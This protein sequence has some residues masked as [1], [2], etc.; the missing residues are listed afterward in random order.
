M[1]NVFETLMALLPESPKKR[2]IRAKYNNLMAARQ[3]GNGLADHFELKPKG[4][5]KIEAID[6]NGRVTGTLADQSNLVV[7]GAEEIMMK[8]LAGDPAHVLYQNRFLKQDESSVYFI[9]TDHLIDV[10]NGENVLAVLPND[11]WS[12]V[13]E[14]EFTT[15]F[16]FSPITVYLVEV[17]S[18][19]PGQKA[20]KI[21]K[22]PTAET[23]SLT[24]ELYSGY[25]PLFI[26]IGDGKNYHVPFNSGLLTLSP[27][28]GGDSERKTTTLNDKITFKQKITNFQVDYK[29][30][31][32]G[33]QFTI[34][35][36][37]KAV[38]T[39]DTYD[40]DL[41]D[42]AYGDGSVVIDSLDPLNESDV[43][44]KFSGKNDA[45]ETPELTIHALYFDA[46]QKN[47]NKLIHELEDFTTVFDTPAYYNTSAGAPYYVQLDHFPVVPS[48]VKVQYN[49]TTFE[50]VEDQED[51]AENKYFVDN[52][53]G[54]IYFT[55]ALT[56][57]LITYE[58]TGQQYATFN[59]KDL[60]AGTIKQTVDSETPIGAIDGQNKS[61]SLANKDIIPES[62]II[63]FSDAELKRGEDYTINNEDGTIAFNTAP[64]K[65]GTITASYQ[66]GISAKKLSF[67]DK[68]ID[69]SIMINDADRGQSYSKVD[70]SSDFKA[71]TFILN[72]DDED[73]KSIL[74]L[75]LTD[76]DPEKAGLEIFFKTDDLPGVPTNYKRQLIV[77]PKRGKDAPW[78]ALDK[79]EIEFVTEFPENLPAMNM[80][81]RE[82]GLFD[83]PRS[84][85]QVRGY[86]NYP[87]KAFSLV[88]V[89]DS[90]K[91]ISTGIRITW[92]ITLLNEDGQPFHGGY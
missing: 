30:S 16:S 18:T 5:I 51:L 77:K 90:I 61:F 67:E 64:A 86:N 58:I 75:P 55:S 50:P 15:E 6:N 24:A 36:N 53:Y 46:F 80:T 33:G 3:K 63:K 70:A 43:E 11:I 12:V 83:G 49:S 48:S 19:R 44:I 34:S 41:A 54:K 1:S 65:G 60:E 21:V 27:G 72:P 57:L 40:K 31:K 14:N 52:K 25:S 4:H 17:E 26:G 8:A 88:R 91:E 89:G 73:H 82:M 32:L 42:G 81:I 39:V 22:D 62:E 47:D 85:D 37:G 38:K 68:L 84:E 76:V 92:T 13:D 45:V 79:G 56:N 23:A 2:M 66:F 71:G 78:F 87:V 35:V 20:F 7:N 29:T 59:L 28:F 74:L 9:Q 69:D 10:V